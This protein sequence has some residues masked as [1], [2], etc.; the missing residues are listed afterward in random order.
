MVS[1]VSLTWAET[2]V[3]IDNG[4]GGKG[5]GFFM[6]RQ[7]DEQ[8]A[9]MFLVTNKHVLDPD[10]DARRGM[11]DLVLHLNV[12]RAGAV[13]GDAIAYPLRADNGES[14]VREHP[15]DNV[16][17]LAIDVSN[18]FLARPDIHCKRATYD[19]I[20]DGPTADGQWIT[21]GD[22]IFVIG[23]PSGLRQGA[24]NY[25]LVRQGIV[26]TRF[27]ETLVEDVSDGRGNVSQRHTR[28]FLIDGATIP[29]SSGSPV[30]LKQSMDQ[31]LRAG[32]PGGPQAR[33]LLLGIL[34]ETRFAPVRTEAGDVQSFAGLGM[35]LEAVT[36]RETIEGFFA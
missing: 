18:L 22:E 12:K 27:G 34:A 5:T 21:A 13:V 30:V 7:L 15:D 2:T 20:V 33:P 4:W 23:Y 31:V 29:G 19:L 32:V 28:G 9:K 17:V 11:T 6:S 26:A 10:A 35:A 8:Y 36:I 1:P 25:P 3:L 24:T 14:L 16:D